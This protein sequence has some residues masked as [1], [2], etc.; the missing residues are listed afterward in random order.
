MPAY[1]N[2]KTGEWSCIINYA[3][4]FY[5]LN[6]NPCGQAGSMGQ[7]IITPPKTKKKDCSRLPSTSSPMKWSVV[8]R[9]PV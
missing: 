7:N 3:K 2:E 4:R 1:K 9:K 5:D 8:A 6:T